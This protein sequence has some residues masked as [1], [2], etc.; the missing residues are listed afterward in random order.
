MRASGQP[1]TG[2]SKA[3]AGDQEGEVIER[4]RRAGRL[5]KAQRRGA[6]PDLDAAAAAR[7]ARQPETIDVEPLQGRGVLG[8]RLEHCGED[9]T[10]A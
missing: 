6:D 10:R 7:S 4:A 8:R 9:F 5:V 1:R 3:V 2:G